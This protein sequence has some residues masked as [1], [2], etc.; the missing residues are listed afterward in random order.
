MSGPVST[1][2]AAEA[3]VVLAIFIMAATYVNAEA[4]FNALTAWSAW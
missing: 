1:A 4:I 2:M 3:V